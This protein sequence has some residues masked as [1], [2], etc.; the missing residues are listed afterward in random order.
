[1]KEMDNTVAVIMTVK[2]DRT[3]CATTLDSLLAQSRTPDE[4]VVVDGGSTDGTAEFLRGLAVENATLRCISAPDTNIARG[5]NI[6]AAAATTSII[7]CTDAGCRL[8]P[9]WLENLLRPF[10]NHSDTEFVA[11][12]YRMDSHTLLEEVV[13]LATMRGQLDPVCADTFNPS[14]R[15]MACRKSVWSQAGGWP[16]WLGFS[17]DTLFDHKVRRMNVRWEFA[18][19]AIVHWRPRSSLRALAKQFYNYGTGRGQTQIDA[20]GF[21]YNLR[22]M[23]LVAVAA[24]MCLI[25]NWAFPVLAGLAGYFYVW[26]FH[27]KARRIAKRTR[28][29]LA[30][31]LCLVVQWVVLFF[32]VAGYLVGSW[33]RLCDRHAYAQRMDA[34]LSTPSPRGPGMSGGS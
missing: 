11:G 21:A 17:E 23:L 1:M 5:R 12:F 8:E 26:A 30:Y 14:A 24:A 27:H 33:Q 32:H 7:A 18:G 13:G 22:N 20:A 31:P 16:E 34:Y 28:R 6:A 9:D 4:I 15:S 10:E 2:N 25:T 19:D 3:A 29:L